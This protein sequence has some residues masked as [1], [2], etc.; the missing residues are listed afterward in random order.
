M[1][2][3]PITLEDYVA[4]SLATNPGRQRAEFVARL[5]KTL[6][7]FKAGARCACGQRI[8]VI[9]SAEVG[10]GCFT[11]ITGEAHPDSDYEI[12]EISGRG[13]P[14][15]SRSQRDRA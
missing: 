3:V 10:H 14:R 12:A 6:G 13:R 4:K 15:K 1:P 8:W 11:C 9:G 5:R 2:F 7:D